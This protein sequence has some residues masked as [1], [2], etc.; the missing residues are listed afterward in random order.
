MQSSWKPA[1]LDRL[2]LSQPNA[3]LYGTLFGVP[4]EGGVRGLSGEAPMRVRMRPLAAPVNLHPEGSQASGAVA[5][6]PRGSE[7]KSEHCLFE[8]CMTVLAIVRLYLADPGE[9]ASKLGCL[10]LNQRAADE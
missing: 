8:G 9:D 1:R 2:G 6:Y 10:T 3:L 4:G 5:H 7:V